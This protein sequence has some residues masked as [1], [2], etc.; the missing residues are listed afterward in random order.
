MMIMSHCHLVADFVLARKYIRVLSWVCNNCFNLES[1]LCVSAI[2]SLKHFMYIFGRL[3]WLPVC[4]AFLLLGV[5]VLVPVCALCGPH[6]GMSVAC[7]Y[8]WW[9]LAFQVCRSCYTFRL[10]VCWDCVLVVLLFFLYYFLSLQLCRSC[11]TCCAIW[12]S[13]RSYY[14]L[15]YAWR[16]DDRPL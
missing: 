5:L 13:R 1:L 4:L 2:S 11:C 9:T 14:F 7:L 8:V 3:C 10:S 16:S 15:P 6:L 12:S